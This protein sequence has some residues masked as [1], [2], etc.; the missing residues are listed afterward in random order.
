[1]FQDI[2]SDEIQNTMLPRETR[3]SYFS[4]TK[5]KLNTNTLLSTVIQYNAEQIIE[6]EMRNSQ[7]KVMFSNL[8]Q[9]NMNRY[10]KKSYLS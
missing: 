5:E 8:K 10:I 9:Y 3:N 6:D 7:N 2:A 4:S 1:M